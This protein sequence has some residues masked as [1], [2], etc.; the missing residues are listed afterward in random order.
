MYWPAYSSLAAVPGG[1]DLAVIVAP[2]GEVPGIMEDCAV[3][4]VS[5]AV[6]ISGGFAETGAEG[7]LLEESIVATAR[8]AHVRLIGPNCFGVISASAGLNASLGMGMPSR[9]G[10][11]LYTQ[12]GAYGTAAFTRSKNFYRLSRWSPAD[13]RRNL[14]ETDMPRAFADDPERGCRHGTELISD[15]AAASRPRAR[16]RREAD[17]R[18]ENGARGGWT[19]RRRQPTAA[20]A[21]DTRFAWWRCVRVEFTWSRMCLTL[22]DHAAAIDRQPPRPAA[23]R[24]HH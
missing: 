18:A 2:P 24:D 3:A 13:K 9:G 4:R 19:P 10:I 1:A 5:V 7:R 12:S 15:G 6:I 21:M 20:S 17:R 16:S 11:A 8:A 22:L 14:D 23:D